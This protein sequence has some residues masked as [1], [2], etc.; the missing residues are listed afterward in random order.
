MAAPILA[1]LINFERILP[2]SK[3][4]FYLLISRPFCGLR[5]RVA[6]LRRVL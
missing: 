1:L 2:L 4:V 3:T 5:S 6:N